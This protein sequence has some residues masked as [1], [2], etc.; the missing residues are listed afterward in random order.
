MATMT[1]ETTRLIQSVGMTSAPRRRGRRL[2]QCEDHDRVAAV[3]AL[4]L[5]CELDRNLGAPARSA[6]ADRDGDVLTTAHGITDREA[7]R[8]RDRPGL[9]QQIAALHVIGVDVSVPVT[10]EHEA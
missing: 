2:R 4:E 7:L 8:R 10:D 9:P 3:R 5:R 1:A 6:D